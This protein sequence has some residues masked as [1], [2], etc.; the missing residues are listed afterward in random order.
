MNTEEKQKR[1]KWV[2]TEVTLMNERF[3]KEFP[4][5]DDLYL[6]LE[7]IAAYDWACD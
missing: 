5:E 6:L 1:F 2:N 3:K 4:D 7:G